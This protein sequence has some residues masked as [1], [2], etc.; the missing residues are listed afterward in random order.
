[1]R[2]PHADSAGQYLFGK[3]GGGEVSLAGIREERNDDFARIF[4]AFC[5]HRRRMHRSTGGDAHEDAL[6]AYQCTSGSVS[7]RLGD[8]DDLIVNRAVEIVRHKVRADAHQAVR[9]CLALGE[10]RF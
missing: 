8:G 3:H 5:K 6:A 1:M 2:C 7:V 4:R 10:Q 9:A